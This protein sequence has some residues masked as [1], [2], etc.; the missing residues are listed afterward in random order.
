MIKG[1]NKPITIVGKAQKLLLFLDTC[2]GRYKDTCQAIN[3]IDYNYVNIL[4][5]TIANIIPYFFSSITCIYNVNSQ[6]KKL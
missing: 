5:T 4:S 6:Q 3:K 1:P 2:R